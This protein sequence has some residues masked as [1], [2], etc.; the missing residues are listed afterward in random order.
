MNEPVNCPICK[1]K[2]IVTTAFD[3]L[4]YRR[5]IN[6]ECLL[7]DYHDD[8]C[9]LG[10]GIPVDMWNKAFG[11]K[12]I[13]WGAQRQAFGAWFNGHFNDPYYE[14]KNRGD[15]WSAWQAALENRDE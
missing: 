8:S 4:Q 7:S 2:T 15:C 11:P 12:E 13:D 14:N 9:T 1:S 3:S 6:L 5:C 10:D